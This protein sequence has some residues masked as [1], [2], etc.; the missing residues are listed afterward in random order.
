MRI[1]VDDDEMGEIKLVKKG[2]IALALV[3]IIA[4]LLPFSIVN[5]GERCVLTEWSAVTGEI[6]NEGLHFRIPIYQNCHMMNVQTQKYVDS[7]SSA[8]MDLQDV[9]TDVA[10]NYHLDPTQVDYVYQTIGNDF[11]NKVIAP[12]I[13]E[14]VKASTALFTAEE[15]ITKRAMAKDTIKINLADRLEPYGI[16]V[17]TVSITNFQFS[18]KFTQAIED[19]VEAEQWALKAGN[20]LV[21]IKI[22]AEQEIAMAE[23]EA[24]AI[25]IKGDAIKNNPGLV[26]LEA[27]YVQREAVK[28][29]GE[30]VKVWNGVLPTFM[31]SGNGGNGGSTSMLL[32]V[33]NFIQEV[34]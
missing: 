26:A 15:L 3:L 29:Q 8:S 27:V 31:M 12:A 6:W 10:V 34:N 14:S 24:R 28:V 23:A 16:V 13:E 32:D 22:E 4:F 11:G 2:G 5:A 9:N 19:K 1:K 17:E 30:A 20:D 33:S 18:A 7:A 21:R 25:Q